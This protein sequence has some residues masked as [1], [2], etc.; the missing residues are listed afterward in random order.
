MVMRTIER[1]IRKDELIQQERLLPFLREPNSY[2]HHPQSVQLVQTHCSFVALAGN[3][4]YKVKKAVNLGFL[5]FST[6]EKRKHFCER[7]VILNR[8]LCPDVYLD[9]VAISKTGGRYVFGEGDKIVE[10]AVRMRR[11]SDRGFLH[12]R[13]ERNRVTRGDLN[14]IA[15]T[16]KRFYDAQHPTREIEIWGSIDRLA[17]STDENFR[18]TKEFIGKTLSRAAF[19]TIQFYTDEFYRPRK[20]LFKSRVEQGWIRDC[21]GDLHAEHIHLTP[22]TVRIYD[23]IEF[24]DRLRYVDVANDVAFLA[25]DLDYEGH[26][27]LGKHFTRKI[28]KAL[29]D[30]KMHQLIDFYKCYRAFVR[31]KVESMH[32]VAHAA[33]ETEKEASAERA[34]RYF[35]LALQY[36]IAGSEPMVIV[37]MG[38][39]A[40]GKSTLAA[41]LSRELGWEV[42]SSDRLRKELAGLPIYQRSAQN[43]QSSLYSPAMTRK[44]YD[45]LFKGAIKNAQRGKSVIL[46]AT[47]AKR[48]QREELK[49][50]LSSNAIRHRII[51]IRSSDRKIK[52][53]LKNRELKRDEVSD[54]RIEDFNMLNAVYEPPTELER[55]A[56]ITVQSS[57]PEQS[58][59]LALRKLA[60]IQSSHGS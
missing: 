32:H 36:A 28:A 53:A 44:T 55:S 49:A 7:E 47:F 24:N 35:R 41:A 27:E 60:S 54:A 12:K 20:S 16:L 50:R 39:V 37:V 57:S 4:V 21:H 40:A 31:G 19:E 11:L 59:K 5:D 48:A 22:K 58:L 18:Q 38:R 51:E 46:D 6:L 8:R 56:I 23:C 9:V 30:S 14:R 10:Y 34:R 13:L 17:I 29:G 26:P 15:A 3:F 42:L 25:M 1:E 43:A 52:E 33:P 2:P 45:A